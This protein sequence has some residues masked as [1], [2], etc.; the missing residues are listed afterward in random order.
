[1]RETGARRALKAE[2]KNGALWQPLV[3]SRPDK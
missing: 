1:M 3:F 2:G